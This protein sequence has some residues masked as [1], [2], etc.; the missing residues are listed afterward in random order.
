LSIVTILLYFARQFSEQLTAEKTLLEE[1]LH[2]INE[3]I[4]QKQAEVEGRI[5]EFTPN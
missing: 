4:P 1:E 2:K 5:I 3:D